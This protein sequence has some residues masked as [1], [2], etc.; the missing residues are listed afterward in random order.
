M[1]NMNQFELINK[2]RRTN[3]I[4]GHVALMVPFY[5]LPLALVLMVLAV[6]L[7]P[8]IKAFCKKFLL[9][10]RYVRIYVT[11]CLSMSTLSVVSQWEGNYASVIFNTTVFTYVW[12]IVCSY[13][14][15][16]IIL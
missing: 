3:T 9:K 1:F 14:V 5:Y 2:C 15:N 11:M 8:T 16:Y 6:K 10:C 12:S 13:V 7:L 4:S